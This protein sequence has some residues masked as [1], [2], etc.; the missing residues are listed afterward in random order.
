MIKHLHGHLA[1]MIVLGAGR[2]ALAQ[3]SEGDTAVLPDETA[4]LEI[5]PGVDDVPFSR[6][7]ITLPARV[8]RADATLSLVRLPGFMGSGSSTDTYLA[9]GAAFGLME[10]LEVG[11]SGYRQG[12]SATTGPASGLLPFQMTQ[13]FKF[14]L[15]TPYARYRLLH[16]DVLQLAA[17]LTV[18]LPTASGSDLGVMFGAP[19]RFT[20]AQRLAIDTGLFFRAVFADSAIT[21]LVLPVGLVVNVT[22]TLFLLAR[23]AYTFLDFEVHQLGVALGAGYTVEADGAPL[24]D[25]LAL[26]GFPSLYSDGNTVTNVWEVN[27]A[28]AFR[29]GL[30]G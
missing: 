27:L 17:E 18:V 4:V 26:F 30:N 23:M 5:E 10:D 29:L 25:V 11:V 1:L 15:V 28:L 13:A 7:G 20:L 6:R 14:G 2:I 21:D 12:S 19:L 24:F 9:L 8:L 16:S 22:P 3:P